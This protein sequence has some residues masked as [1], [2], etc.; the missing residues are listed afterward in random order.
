MIRLNP[1][2]NQ[3]EF[4]KNWANFGTFVLTVGLKNSFNKGGEDVFPDRCFSHA[5]NTLNRVI[6][7]MCLNKDTERLAPICIL[8][9][10]CEVLSYLH[11]NHL[12]H[13]IWLLANPG[14][15]LCMTVP[16]YA[17][18]KF[19]Q[20]QFDARVVSALWLRCQSW[21]QVSTWSRGGTAASCKELPL[22]L[23]TQV[24]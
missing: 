5:T 24:K 20:L 8:F 7:C 11:W 3:S 1:L 16:F 6:L 10:I 23:F 19:T 9:W 17:S 4:L 18:L 14:V 21:V 15:G 13:L 12:F 2:H 22:R